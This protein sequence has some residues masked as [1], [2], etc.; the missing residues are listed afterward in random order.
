MTRSASYG[1][2]SFVCASETPPAL[3]R[4][5]CFLQDRDMDEKHGHAIYEF[6]RIMKS[7]NVKIEE[8]NHENGLSNKYFDYIL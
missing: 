4:S 2:V 6:S 8:D 1:G 3:T 7:S 5:R